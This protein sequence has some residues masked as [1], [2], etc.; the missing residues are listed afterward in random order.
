[1]SKT[2]PCP[3][4]ARADALQEAVAAA[5]VRL[6]D[7]RFVADGAQLLRAPGR[8]RAAPLP[9]AALELLRSRLPDAAAPAPP[10]PH[11]APPASGSPS[12]PEAASS[13]APPVGADR[14]PPSSPA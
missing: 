5:R 3:A 10:P 4:Q 9:P 13:A 7:R 14:C 6:A 2:D 8:P 12:V 11:S 1:M